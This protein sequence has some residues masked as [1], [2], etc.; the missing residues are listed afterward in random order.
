MLPQPGNPL[1]PTLK[2][3][4]S[5]LKKHSPLES[6]GSGLA[7]ANPT[8]NLN[9]RSVE[10]YPNQPPLQQGI[11]KLAAT[12]SPVYTKQLLDLRPTPQYMTSEQFARNRNT[13][14]R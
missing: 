10:Q 12:R 8:L 7:A 5:A 2:V 6:V 11:G 9:R 4:R 14:S 13:L 3:I 1:Q